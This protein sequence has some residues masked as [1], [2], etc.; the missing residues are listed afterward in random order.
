MTYSPE[1][2]QDANNHLRVKKEIRTVTG[3][4]LQVV[5]S[6]S[7]PRRGVKHETYAI[8]HSA[9]TSK[10]LERKVVFYEKMVNDF[11]DNST[12]NHELQIN[13]LGSANNADIVSGNGH[14]LHL[15]LVDTLLR[16]PGDQLNGWP[17]VPNCMEITMKHAG[18][19]FELTSGNTLSVFKLLSQ[20]E[21]E[22]L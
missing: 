3:G 13:L 12:H 20:I 10:A 2:W 7:S 9:G 4:L 1:V 11:L 19:S 14:V 6:A 18:G 16:V 8:S 5:W 22:I 17:T 15:R 21:C